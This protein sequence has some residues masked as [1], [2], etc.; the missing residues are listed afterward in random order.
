VGCACRRWPV[1]TDRHHAVDLLDHLTDD[2][3]E[4]LYAFLAQSLLEF[5]EQEAQ[6]AAA[7]PPPPPEPE[8]L[9]D[10]K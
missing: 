7:E 3:R 6:Q 10:R 9:P 5:I 2:D 4:A 8:P 1:S